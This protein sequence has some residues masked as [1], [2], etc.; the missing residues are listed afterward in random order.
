MFRQLASVAAIA[1]TALALG[2][3]GDD[4]PARWH[5]DLDGERRSPHHDPRGYHRVRR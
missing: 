2:G 3:C 1:I 4:K 5:R